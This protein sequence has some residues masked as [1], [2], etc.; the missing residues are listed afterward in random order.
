MSGAA[1]VL[2]NTGIQYAK[3][4]LT[5]VLAFLSTR[6]ILS[7]LGVTDF[8]VFSLVGGAI[9][10][11]SFVNLAMST[12]SQRFLS[13]HLGSGDFAA[14]KSSFSASQSLHNLIGIGM[15]L[16]LEILGFFLFQGFLN[17]PP[18]RVSATWMVYHCI[19][20]GSTV[21][22]A[23]VPYDALLGA[24]ED[25][26]LD[27]ILSV[28]DAVA[29]V[30]LAWSL[31]YYEGDRLVLF[32]ACTAGLSVAV[33]SAK[34]VACSRRY[35][36]CVVRLGLRLREEGVREMAAFAGW[37]L[38]GSMANVVRS[39]GLGVVMNLFLGPVVNAAYGIANQVNG[40]VSFLSAALMRSI[41]PQILKREGSGDRQGMLRLA[42]TSSKLSFFLLAM[43]A[44]PLFVGMDFVLALWLVK[45]P[46]GAALLCRF[47]L[48]M[49]LVS[50]STVGLQTAIQALGRIR[51]YQFAVGGLLILMLPM[52]YVV[53]RLGGGVVEV[54]LGVILLEVVAVLVRIGF[55]WRLGG[56]APVGYVRDVLLR[57][58][59]TAF[60]AWGAAASLAAWTEPGW[61]SFLLVEV[62]AVASTGFGAYFLGLLPEERDVV[63]RL[64]ADRIRR[65]RSLVAGP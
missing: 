7:S 19:A 26:G 62:V 57:C 2:R 48:L 9:A 23:G 56:L 5:A 3:L 65:R 4:L 59:P 35:P 8:G 13:I 36:E 1:R 42:R 38:F 32:G 31:Q 51:G 45:V 61:M 60:L 30:V 21:A 10:F 6:M 64:V 33:V 37:N 50:Q 20:F 52:A 18:D 47:I 54:F 16:F 28:C 44:I 12:S 24:H 53:L 46:P 17:I 40:Q 43:L 25:L 22:I 34:V 27:A 14:L 15:F 29:R 55:L 63:S 58:W 11:L 39:Q 41:N 49:S